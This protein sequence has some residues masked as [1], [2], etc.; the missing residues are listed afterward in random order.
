MSQVPELKWMAWEITRR[1]NLRCVHCRSASDT[2][3]AT[4]PFS[5]AM[6]CGFLDQVAAFGSPVVVLTG[7]EPLLR[8]DVFELAQH[9]TERGLR[10]CIATNGTLVDADVCARLRDAG[11][12]MVA[13][14][15]D[16]A[17]AAVHDRFRQQPGAFEA[18]LR[19]AEWL[20]A[21]GLKFLINSSF[22]RHN[23]DEIPRVHA[24]AKSLGAT[25]WY[26]F[27]VVPTGRGEEL[28]AELVSKED[29]EPILNAH[30]DIEA[31]ETELL[32]RPTCAPQYYRILFERKRAGGTIALDRRSLALSTGG[33]KGC[34]AG[35]SIAL[36][37]FEGNLLP[38]SYFPLAAGN[39][40][41]T[42]LG[43]IW[44]E[45]P[46]LRELRDPAQLEGR[47]GVCEYRHVCG[48]CR[49]RAYAVTGRYLAVDPYCDYV[50]L[51]Q[52]RQAKAR[53][54]S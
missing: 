43:E 8:P 41:Q 15:L 39:V 5:T 28:L 1:C 42:P 2:S 31:A 16:G 11:I 22:T 18:T 21:A 29:Y 13:L 50:P 46:L 4:S 3:F 35:Q 12:R 32:V 38:C 37:D 6:G 47:C 24:L 10:M 26:M 36:V 44:A 19:A 40:W 51:A 23:Q 54:A 20:R 25:A 48:G 7:G 14:S 52:R 53:D 9:G 17:S 30:Y 33:Q 45:S 34:I 49:A 27:L